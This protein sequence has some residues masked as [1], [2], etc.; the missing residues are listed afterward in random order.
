MAEKNAQTSV[1]TFSIFQLQL[2]EDEAGDENENKDKKTDGE[3]ALTENQ[4]D[5]NPAP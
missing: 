2:Q 3:I 5:K 1:S 4:S